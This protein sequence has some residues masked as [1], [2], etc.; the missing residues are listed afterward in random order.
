MNNSP[1]FQ[2]EHSEIPPLFLKYYWDDLTEISDEVKGYGHDYVNDFPNQFPKGF[3]LMS[4]VSGTGKS[5]FATCILRDIINSGKTKH[6]SIFKPFIHLMDEFR[7][8]IMNGTSLKNSDLFKKIMSTDVLV[9]DDVGVDKM[10]NSMA[11]RYYILVDYL[12]QYEKN[13]IFTS[14][15]TYNE[16]I[17]RAEDNVETELLES[18]VSRIRG[19]CG[20]IIKLDNIRDYRADVK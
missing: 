11:Q 17:D 14:K 10:N 7:E 13:V 9:L 19:M 12:W 18:I 4:K 20:D 2:L 1:E 5:T 8:I 15:F 3:Y 6:I 16:L